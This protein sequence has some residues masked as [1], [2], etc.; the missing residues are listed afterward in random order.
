MMLEE[1]KTLEKLEAI[2]KKLIASNTE[3][4]MATITTIEGL[5]IL[6]VLPRKSNETI[7][8]AMV[9]TLLSLSERTVAEMEIG[10]FNQLSIQG[11]DG[12]LL[13]FDAEVAVLAVS[14]TAKAQLG[15]IIFEC[16][17]A[18]LEIANILKE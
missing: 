6:S 14:T 16:E 5:P 3:L 12:S 7:I 18:A 13:V 9:A 1:N 11:I 15:L 17:R 2:L 10:I 8:S 4:T